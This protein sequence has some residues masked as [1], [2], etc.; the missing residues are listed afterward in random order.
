ME[1]LDIS[2]S[3]TNYRYDVKIEKKIK[4]KRQEFGSVNSSQLKQGKGGPKQQK[5]GKRK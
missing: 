2:S 4:Q 5:K 1:F 3:S